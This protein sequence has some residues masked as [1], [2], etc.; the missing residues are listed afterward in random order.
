M[1]VANDFIA[2]I[3]LFNV[4]EKWIGTCHGFGK[5][6]KSVILGAPPAEWLEPFTIQKVT[7]DRRIILRWQNNRVYTQNA[8]VTD[9][10]TELLVTPLFGVRNLQVGGS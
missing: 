10:G 4:N 2:E 9:T 5:T 3:H 8:D 1:T 7:E 6:V